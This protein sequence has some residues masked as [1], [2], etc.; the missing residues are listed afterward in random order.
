[1]TLLSDRTLL[2][3]PGYPKSGTTT[4]QAGLFRN[5]PDLFFM[6]KTHEEKM[7]DPVIDR[8]RTLVNYGTLSHVRTEGPAVAARIDEI[9]QAN[10]APTALMSLEGLTNPFVDTHYTQPRDIL[11]KVTVIAD[12]LAHIDAKFRCLVTLRVQTKLLPSL[13]SQIFLQGFSSGLFKPDYE[14]FLDFLLEDRVQGYGPD[15]RFDT[16]LDH[17]GATF[18]PGNIFAADMKGLLAGTPGRDTAAVA[19]FM[20]LTEAETI[21]L[22]RTGGRLNVRDTGT[23]GRKMVM[24]SPGVI[25]F[26]ENTGLNVR[27]AAFGRMALLRKRFHR[28]AHWHLADHSDRIAAYY[29]ESNVRLAERY[30][31]AF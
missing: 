22:I 1:M 19:A 13:F 4:L 16:Y 6:G 2:L 26:E 29:A 11:T 17:L 18:G 20:K 15:F 5:A 7:I 24:Q 30:E 9:W 3:H 12:I 27:Q 21:D 8:F 23:N 14:S 31:I 28:N 10:G 25:Q